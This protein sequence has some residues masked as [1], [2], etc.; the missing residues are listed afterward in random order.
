MN[1]CVE[2]TA[3]VLQALFAEFAEE[4]SQVASVANAVIN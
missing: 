3:S 1:R 2:A 4:D